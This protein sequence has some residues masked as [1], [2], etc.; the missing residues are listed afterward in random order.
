[1]CAQEHVYVSVWD[2]EYV[3][4]WVIVCV[5]VQVCACV[6]VCM[7]VCVCVCECV[8]DWVSEWLRVWVSVWVSDCECECLL[9]WI[10]DWLNVCLSWMNGCMIDCQMW[11]VSKLKVVMMISWW[12]RAYEILCR[13]WMSNTSSDHQNGCVQITDQNKCQTLVCICSD[14]KSQ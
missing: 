6:H 2:V 4:G 7:C 10:Y 11:I 5:C 3:K 13:R 12:W 1:M 14:A 9:D 8:R